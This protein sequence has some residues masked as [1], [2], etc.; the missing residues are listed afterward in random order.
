MS[1]GTTAVLDVRTPGEY[2]AAIPGSHLL[3]PDQRGAHADHRT[4]GQQ[5]AV[6][7]G[8]HRCGLG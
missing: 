5:P 8:L 1:A 4:I 2:A 3:P 6:S 7:G